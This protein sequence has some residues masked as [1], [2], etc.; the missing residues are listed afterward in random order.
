MIK[1]WLGQKLEEA[2]ES[3]VAMEDV[4]YM[5]SQAPSS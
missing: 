4:V 1:L 2:H 3:L 5:V